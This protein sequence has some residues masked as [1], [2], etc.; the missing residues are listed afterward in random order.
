MVD[1]TE[2]IEAMI[3]YGGNFVQNLGR[4]AAHADPVNLAK[5]KVT[6]PKYW[7]EYTEFA[8]IDLSRQQHSEGD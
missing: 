8:E 3:K 4:A 2:V 5:M 7:E 6:W 1:D